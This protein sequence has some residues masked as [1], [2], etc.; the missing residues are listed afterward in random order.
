[1]KTSLSRLGIFLFIVS[2]MP[3]G[4]AAGQSRT[5]HH[6]TWPARY[7][8]KLLNDTTD[9]AIPQVRAYP[10][11]AYSPET[12]WE[13][14][15]SS[16]L[17]YYANRDTTNRLSE[18]TGFTFVTLEQQYGAW[19]DHA[20]YTQGNRWF[21]LGRIRLQ[22]FPLY[23][24][25]I[26][27]ET[28]HTPVALVKNRQVQFRERALRQV[29]RN[30]FAGVEVDFQKMS[31]V[32]FDPREGGPLE[33]PT[34]SR[35]SSNLGVGL[36]VLYDNR[37]N[38]LNV[39][40]GLFSE[41]AF[42]SYNHRWGSEYNFNTLQ[43]DT[44]VFRPVG[45]RNVVAFQALGQFNF[46]DVPFNQLALMGGE[47][48]MRGYY[49]GR[50]RDKSMVAA[51]IEYRMLPLPFD[52]TKRWGAA[53]FAS[54]GNVFDRAAEVRLD[55]TLWAAGA[56]ARFLLFPKKDIYTRLDVAFTPEGSGIYLF[57]GEAF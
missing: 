50:F 46:G 24:H 14:G 53:V 21:F 52:F 25:G 16:V 55:R 56:G 42:M 34:G 10:T 11:A 2:G 39:R 43:T 36:G 38:I 3:A 29:Y 49:L 8:Q 57:I 33:L 41:V 35:G 4:P 5:V 9:R 13:L 6:H 27:F 30:V 23:Y 18:V 40:K 44:R 51:Q 17:V 54:A 1:L 12:S 47:S 45:R 20:L 48:I 19:F 32:V 28:P 7:L 37:H 22:D 31:R 15:L 26:G